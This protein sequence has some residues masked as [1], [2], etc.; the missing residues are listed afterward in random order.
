MQC[1]EHAL[2][3]RFGQAHR[4]KCQKRMR[5]DVIWCVHGKVQPLEGDILALA[6]DPGFQFRIERVAMDA[7]VHEEFDDFD[8]PTHVRRHRHRF[9]HCGDFL[10]LKRIARG[11]R[12]PL[13]NDAQKEACK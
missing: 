2:R 3:L 7:V 6:L 4:L 10:S 1:L 5:L 9:G 13:G 8:L 11:C 12:R